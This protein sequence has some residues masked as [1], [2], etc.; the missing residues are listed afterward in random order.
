MRTTTLAFFGLSVG[1]TFVAAST[2]LVSGDDANELPVKPALGSL[3]PG[4]VEP[5]GWL[6]D[7]ALAAR[8]GITG[9]LDEY[10]PTFR[11]GWKGIPIETGGAQPGGT[12]WPL[13]QCSYWLDGLVQ[14]GYILHDDVLLQKAHARLNLVVEGV[15]RGGASFIYW[16]TEKPTEFNSWAHSH[17]GRALAAW[18]EAAGDKRILDAMVRAYADYPVPMGH[19]RF[20]EVSGLCN[21]DAMLKT[22]TWS[23]D[24]RLP[25]RIRA[26]F[27]TPENQATIQEWLDNEFSVGHTV[28]TYEAIRLPALFYLVT[29]EAKYLQASRNAFRWLDEHHTLPHGVASGMEYVS[30]VGALRAT[31]TCDIAAQM[32]STAWLYQITGERS[33]GDSIERAFF[34]AA[35]ASVARDWQTICYYQSPNR[36]STDLPSG[37]RARFLFTKLGDSGVPCCV[38]NVNRLIPS[39]VTKMWMTTPDRGLA[40]TLYGPCSVTAVVGDNIPVKLACQTAYP[41]EETNRVLVSPERPASFPLRFRI[42]GWCAK[43]RISVNGVAVGVAQGKNG[44]VRIERQW[45]RGDA[46][47]LVFPMPVRVARFRN[48]V[49]VVGQILLPHR[50]FIV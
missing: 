49:P 34:N 12:G 8:N 3:P 7:W 10:H 29:G 37:E 42:P 47:V 19:L 5:A 16:K 2:R 23:H 9:H 21:I 39:Y 48:G 25:D 17:M 13:E 1:L 30:G 50:S 27:N 26:A 41:F 32:W 20:N 4:A 18:Y 6:R 45:T 44:F 43:P 36:V 38:G 40:A 24:H 35:P 15:N 22:Y 46:V 14:L 11:D 33:W 28:V 31:E